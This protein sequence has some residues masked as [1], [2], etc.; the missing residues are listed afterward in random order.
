M[1]IYTS[2]FANIKKLPKNIIPISISRFPPKWFN[3][4]MFK[5]LAPSKEILLNYKGN[6]KLYIQKY[7][8][9]ILD[10]LNATDIYNQLQELS[11][12]YDIALVCFEKPTDFCHRHIVS[13]WLNE[14]LNLN[15][16]EYEPILDEIPLF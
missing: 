12:G 3:G 13:K 4:I 15:V 1:K 6:H 2:Y 11:N 5:Q 10:N 16:L 14:K 7:T 9:E 8:A